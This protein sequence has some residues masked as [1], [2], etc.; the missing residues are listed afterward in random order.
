MM[1]CSPSDHGAVEMTLSEVAPDELLMP[2]V[3]LR[4]FQKAVREQ[5]PIGTDEEV[6]M[7]NDWEIKMSLK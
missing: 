3:E 6:K 7:I 1:P 5:Q 4:D 2:P